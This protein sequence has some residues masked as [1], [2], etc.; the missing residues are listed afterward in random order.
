[1]EKRKIYGSEDGEFVWELDNGLFY[2]DQFKKDVMIVRIPTDNEA[3]GFTDCDEL[4]LEIGEDN[5]ETYVV[6]H[7][8]SL[9]NFKDIA[10]KVLRVK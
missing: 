5:S 6:A 3:N 10:R 2:L 4:D 1:M 9:K 8:I 7:T